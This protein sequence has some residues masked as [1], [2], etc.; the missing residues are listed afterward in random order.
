MNKGAVAVGLLAFSL[1]PIWRSG[2]RDKISLLEFVI[3]HT[4]FSPYEALY[5][6]EEYLTREEIA[7]N[8]NA[9]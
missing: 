1:L 5:V 9:V 2:L 3:G 4:V 6:P 7:R 8:A